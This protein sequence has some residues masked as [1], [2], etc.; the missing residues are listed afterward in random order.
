[1][2]IKELPQEVEGLPVI[3]GS[4]LGWVEGFYARPGHLAHVITYGGPG[5]YH[6]HV[7]RALRIDAMWLRVESKRRIDGAEVAD[8]IERFT[9]LA[10]W[11]EG[12]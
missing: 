4:F 5:L 10:I 6:S 3:Q 12:K 7:M 9:E 1:M 2:K 8:E 11:P